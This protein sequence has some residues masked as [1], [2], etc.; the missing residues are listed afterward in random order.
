M[1]MCSLHTLA[2]EVSVFCLGTLQCPAICPPGPPG[3]PGMPGFKVNRV[4]GV[5]VLCCFLSTMLDQR[6]PTGK[7][8]TI[9]SNLSSTNKS[10]SEM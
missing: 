1:K 5:F 10:V 9:K 8:H 2:V 3:P 6:W 7:S 4:L